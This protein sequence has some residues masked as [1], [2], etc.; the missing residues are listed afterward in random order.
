MITLL[1]LYLI[2]ALVIIGVDLF[3]SYNNQLII[4]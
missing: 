4:N 3:S 2:A 1:G